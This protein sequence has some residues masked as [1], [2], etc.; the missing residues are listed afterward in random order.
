M[1]TTT[2][3]VT[4]VEHADDCRRKDDR[5]FLFVERLTR[6]VQDA[7]FDKPDGEDLICVGEKWDLEE[8]MEPVSLKC[9]DC[10]RGTYVII[11][12][13]NDLVALTKENCPRSTYGH[14]MDK[15]CPY[16]DYGAKK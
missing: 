11:D 8:L 12:K 16:C 14:Y 13:H 7:Y 10:F 4:D 5:S 9:G 15:P 6:E 3:Y 1:T 2:K